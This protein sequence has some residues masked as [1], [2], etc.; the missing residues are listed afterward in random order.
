MHNSFRYYVISVLFEL[1]LS[2][3]RATLSLSPYI[4]LSPPP[5]PGI[6][7]VSTLLL[8]YGCTAH[9]DIQKN[10][11][12]MMCTQILYPN[13]ADLGTGG[14]IAQT[15]SCRSEGLLDYYCMDSFLPRSPSQNYFVCGWPY[16]YFCI[17]C[18]TKQTRGSYM[19]IFIY[20]PDGPTTYTHIYIPLP[21]RSNN[22]TAHNNQA[23][24]QCMPNTGNRRSRTTKYKKRRP[25]DSPDPKR[26][27]RSSLNVLCTVV[28]CLLLWL[29]T[30]T[31]TAH[32]RSHF[33]TANVTS[34]T[35]AGYPGPV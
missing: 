23:R 14:I 13:P 32:E 28:Y 30:T 26:I 15:P 18:H 25:P 33:S 12:I 29:P 8:L 34:C 2:P 22:N 17:S 20:L 31:T 1:Q 7:L 16:L 35:Q 27:S 3:T 11:Y 5:P 6:S 10:S 19:A 24:N 21:P 9:N 4:S